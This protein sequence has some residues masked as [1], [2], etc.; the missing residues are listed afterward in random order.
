MST[1]L[2]DL[3]E[4]RDLTHTFSKFVFL[5]DRCNIFIPAG[6]G[7]VNQYLDKNDNEWYKECL[8]FKCLNEIDSERKTVRD[9]WPSE[10]DDSFDDSFDELVR[11]MYSQI[12][13]TIDLQAND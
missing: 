10:S 13:N 8:C 7:A 4:H 1:E 12:D 9:L 11:Y 3:L 2:A 5:C 6:G